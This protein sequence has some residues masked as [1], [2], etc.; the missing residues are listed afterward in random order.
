MKVLGIIVNYRTPGLTVEAVRG[1]RP[2]IDEVGGRIVVVDNDSGDGSF[3]QLETA[4]KTE[5]WS[6][7]VD[8]IA[9]DR[10]G[11]FG[12][13]NNVG[14]RRAFASD[15]PPEYVYLL[16]PDAVP[17]PGALATL[18]NTMDARP[19]AGIAGSFVH[20][21]NGEPFVNGFRFYGVL[22]EIEGNIRFGP[23]TKLLS[24]NAVVMLPSLATTEEVDWVVG[25][26]M[27]VRRS[28]LDEIGLFDEAFFL[29][30]EETELCLRAQKAGWKTL[31]VPESSVGH[32]GSASTGAYDVQKRQ[33]PYWF[34]SRRYYYEKH[35]GRL[36]TELADAAFLTGQVVWKAR[37]LVERKPPRDPVYYM[38]DFLSHKLGLPR[39]P[40][41]PD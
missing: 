26:S 30:F 19:D 15:D 33:P 8:L 12:Y 14:M 41:A 11:G 2:Q 39:W 16:N 25:A 5:G 22:S 29:Y 28:M 10:N 6:D 4:L 32:I 36:Y 18:V 37:R 40:A 31:Y 21:M 35:F 1:L 7:E 9:S 38:R 34:D 27:M 23:L 13:G 24:R 3:E 20:E 17:D